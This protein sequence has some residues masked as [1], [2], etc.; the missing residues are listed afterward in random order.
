MPASR[1]HL[2]PLAVLAGFCAVAL[3]GPSPAQSPGDDPV[4]RGKYLALLGG[5]AEC[6]SAEAGPFAGGRNFHSGLGTVGS[7][8]ITPDPATGIGA[9]S[10]DDFYR[11]LHTGV[12]RKVGHLYPAFPY[13][14]FTNIARQDADDLF[15][16]L[17]TAPPI[18]NEPKRDQ[19]SFPLNIRAIMGVWNL[20]F[21]HEGSF[22]PDPDR[23][24]E[25]NRGA[26]I[27]QALAHC[28]D[29]HTPKNS[30][31]ADDRDR[32]LQGGAVEGWF[33]PSLT[34]EP[35]T[36]LGAWSRGDIALF[37]KTG[38]NRFTA[39][40]GMMA[41]VVAGST[42]KW[43]DA[44]IGAVA[45][46]L[47]S[48]PATPPASV[49]PAPDAAS[50]ARGQA[51]FEAS[52]ARCHGAN[53]SP[54]RGPP[55]PGSALTQAPNPATVIRYVLAGSKTPVTAAHPKPEAMPAFGDKLSDGDIADVANYIRNA[56]G[57][58]ASA[59][60]PADVAKARKLAAAG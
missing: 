5:C 14:Y 40:G 43:D 48:L 47:K 10:Q 15:A 35:R 59:V 58:Q 18:R 16:Y 57:N 46:Y 4:A 51:V 33:A 1:R 13:P 38:Q 19:L 24:A 34:Q 29:C 8:N 7:A 42:S 25:W 53:A 3:S 54:E 21:F 39:A 20:L 9:W 49:T 60:R 30:L 12:S 55:L 11:A 32:A 45:T 6:H 41:G 31:Q 37:L 23:T 56:W 36:G 50:Q 27:V 52:C 17:R 44:D 28:G 2:R 22:R 26:Y